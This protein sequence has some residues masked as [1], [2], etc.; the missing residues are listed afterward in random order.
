VVVK[1]TIFIVVRCILRYTAYT[2]ANIAYIQETMC[3]D[4]AE[5]YNPIS[6]YTWAKTAKWKQ[7]NVI[8][9]FIDPLDSTIAYVEFMADYTWHGERQSLHELSRFQLRGNRWFYTG[10]V[11]E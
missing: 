11:I 1:N 6:A 10:I 5:N 7:L 4:A 9:D 3:G 2:Q 8:R